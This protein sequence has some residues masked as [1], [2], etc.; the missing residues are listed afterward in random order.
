MAKSP[1]YKDWFNS[2]FYHKLYF[3]HDEK[4]AGDFIQRLLTHINPAPGSRMLDIGCGRGRHSK[5]LASRGYDVTGFDLSPNSIQWAKQFEKE[6]LH[7]VIHDMRLPFYS[8]YFDFAFNFF[9]SFGYFRTRREHDAAMRTIATALRQGG[10][11]II[12]YLNTHYVE[13]HLIPYETK[14]VGETRYEMNRWDTA[15]HFFKKIIVHDPSLIEPLEFT[16]EIAKFSLGDFTDML[17][18]QGLQIQD[19]FGDYQLSR[20]DI[21]ATPRM[22]I[23]AK[24]GINKKADKEKRLYSDGRKTDALT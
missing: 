6:N 13:N 9:T 8:N 1:W 2:G 16:E 5:I 18:Y 19:V 23:L 3:E 7:F 17:S 20:Y 4:A 21:V 12:D 15:T 24:G 22:I 10:S 14:Q 11:F